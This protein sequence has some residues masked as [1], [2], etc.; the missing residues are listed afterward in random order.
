MHARE[1]GGIGYMR[2]QY[3]SESERQ[4][5]KHDIEKGTPISRKSCLARDLF[6]NNIDGEGTF[7]EVPF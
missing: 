6:S 2:I 5:E 3:L 1:C 7:G 4:I